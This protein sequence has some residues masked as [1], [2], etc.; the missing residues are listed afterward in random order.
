MNKFGIGKSKKVK[1]KKLEKSSSL[2]EITMSQSI[3][4]HDVV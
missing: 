1:M 3:K 4:K 2:T